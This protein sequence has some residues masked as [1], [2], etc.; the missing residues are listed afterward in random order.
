MPPPNFDPYSGQITGYQ[1][2]MAQYNPWLPP[3]PGF[4][5]P[6]EISYGEP[7]PP[8]IGTLG[9]Q[10]SIM[11]NLM[12]L[13]RDPFFNYAVAA[14]TGA[15]TFNYDLLMGNPTGL[16]GLDA[17][18]GGGGG[19]GYDTGGYDTSGGYSSGGGFTPELFTTDRMKTLRKSDD[20]N[21]N[22]IAELTRKGVDPGTIKMQL[23]DDMNTPGSTITPEKLDIYNSAV[24][25][26][27]TEYTTFNRTQLQNK[28]GMAMAQQAAP[29][30]NTLQEYFTGWGTPTPVPYGPGNWPGD[31]AANIEAN[32][33]TA[34]EDV[35][36]RNR[37][38]MARL[39]EEA[40]YRPEGYAL[41][42][43]EERGQEATA[44]AAALSAGPSAI[45]GT[46]PWGGGFVPP[47]G[48]AEPYTP[49]T[50]TPGQNAFLSSAANAA[51]G[52][53]G[54]VFGGS[55]VSDMFGGNGWLAQRPETGGYEMNAP[56]QQLD[57]L[58]NQNQ[59]Y[60]QDINQAQRQYQNIIQGDIAESGRTPQRDAMNAQLNY[61]RSMGLNI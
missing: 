10:I 36:R 12:D 19:G 31:M 42:T 9:D 22:M 11:Q 23:L 4:I 15:P 49:S 16:P 27:F 18:M 21:M 29:E 48:P 24:D 50:Q 8:D 51:S 41:K 20:R 38:A 52:T 14:E 25:D 35:I 26:A 57:W 44:H 32:M 60:Q 39:R 28:Q 47:P 13:R 40:R 30:M 45:S 7:V 55:G 43:P 1:D 58:R 5:A 56:A 34:G 59:Q 3:Q 53:W 37:K 6:T 54:G 33:P 46:S 17:A 2:P 61:L